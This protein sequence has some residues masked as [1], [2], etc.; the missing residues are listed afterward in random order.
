MSAAD[1]TKLDGIASG[2]TANTGTVTSVSGAGGYGGLT[3][4]GTVTTSGNL[5]LGGTPTGTWPISVSGSSASTVSPVFTGD[6]AV[7][8]NIT[9]RTESGFYE[10]ST[11]TL[12]EGWPTN[13]N[14]WHHLIACT[15]SNDANYYSL[16]LSS[17]FFDQ[18]LY[19]RATNGVGT[20]AWS[21]LLHSGNYNTYAPTLTGTGASG[22][23]GIN[24]TGNAATATTLQ[25]ART[26]NGVSFDGSANITIPE[27]D[28]L[29]TVTGRG[30]TTATALALTNTTASTAHTN[31]ALTVSGGVGIAGRTSV[32]DI[33][34]RIT[35]A[36]NSAWLQQDGTGRTHWYW[37]TYGGATPVYTVAGEDASS[38]TLHVNNGAGAGGSFFHRSANG[39]GK[40]AGEAI[41]WT[42]TIYSDLNSFTWKGHTVLRSDNYNS[43]SPTLT[44]IGASGTWGISI[45]GNAAT[46]TNQANS[47]T[48]PGSVGITPSNIVVR[49]GS[50]FI[51]ANYINFN[52]SETE[53]PVISSFFT[54]NGDGWARKSSLAHVKNSIRGIADG[55]WG[56]SITGNAATVTNG[57]YLTTAQTLTNKTVTGLRE[58]KIA[59]PASNID[60]NSG[61]FFTRTIS[62]ATT[63]TVSNAAASG[64]ASSFILELTNAGSAA[65]TW[66][67]GVKW[68]GGT[69]PVLTA[70]GV[71]ILGFYTHDGGTTW[72]GLLLSKDSK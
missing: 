63:L 56:I 19:F 48:I 67:S 46:I 24:I 35:S 32:N 27:T 39:V 25:T 14:N 50:G 59:I 16:Q 60:L 6:S 20:T 40:A 66:F 12:A 8:D 10:S 17:T 28:T 70:S 34:N 29:A 72:R 36:G 5:T 4:S 62:G 68:T 45:T 30:A 61:N 71:D 58:T 47:A 69:A 7:K 18:Q 53:N 26:I 31:G 51:Y 41:T 49:D 38:I 57:V 64:S 13:G 42:T 43:Y 22:T 55:T 2:A 21:T 23:W 37:N 52:Q 44:G 65:I 1:K 54:S 11:G 33:V 9:T 3:L 15:H